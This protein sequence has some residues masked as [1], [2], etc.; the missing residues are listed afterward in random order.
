M[1]VAAA[2]RAELRARVVWLG[3]CVGLGVLIALG[4]VWL[5]LQVVNTGYRLSVTRQ[6]IERLYQEERELTLDIA[7][8]STATRIEEIARQRLGMTRPENGQE[9]VLP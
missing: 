7:R 6:I 4:H 3:V 5:R 8:L 9:A 2:A 1:N